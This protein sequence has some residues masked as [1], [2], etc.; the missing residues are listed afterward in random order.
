[1][2]VGVWGSEL[3]QH[4]CVWVGGWVGV[5]VWAFVMQRR[6]GVVGVCVQ[7]QRG[8]VHVC[9]Y[10]YLGM[11]L[12]VSSGVC[13][14]LC[15]RVCVCVCVCVCVHVCAGGEGVGG[16]GCMHCGHTGVWECISRVDKCV[17]ACVRVC[18]HVCACM[19]LCVQVANV[20]ARCK[21]SL[22]LLRCASF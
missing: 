18:L 16:C 14:Y 19:C 15:V 3:Q 13:G 21:N 10:G 5:G 2:R 7:Q 6:C 17:C 22:I 1:V 11:N 9:T 8:C 12:C 20:C 4:G